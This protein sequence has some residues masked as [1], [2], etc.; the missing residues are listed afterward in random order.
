MMGKVVF[1][2][3]KLPRLQDDENITDIEYEYQLMMSWGCRLLSSMLVT[4]HSSTASRCLSSSPSIKRFVLQIPY[5]S[6]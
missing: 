3:D 1:R 4:R 5:T 2:P 6:N